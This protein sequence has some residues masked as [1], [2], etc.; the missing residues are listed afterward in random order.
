DMLCTLH[1]HLPPHGVSPLSLHDALPIF[2]ADALHDVGASLNPA[3]D[4]G[5]VEGAFIQGMG[6]LTLEELW[7]NK[8]GRLM[9]HAPSTY[10]VPRSEEH[11]SE[12]QSRCDLVCRLLLEQKKTT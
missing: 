7:W 9:T 3:I 1:H 11:T 5:Q 12:L 8:E 10:K 2:R 4:V 6:W